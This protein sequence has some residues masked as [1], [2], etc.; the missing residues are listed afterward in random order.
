MGPPYIK[1]G[2]VFRKSA[3]QVRELLPPAL[4]FLADGLTDDTRVSALQSVLSAIPVTESQLVEIQKW[5]VQSTD[6][7]T[8]ALGITIVREYDA[9]EME[10]FPLLEFSGALNQYCEV[11]NWVE[12]Y[13]GRWECGTCRR[14]DWEQVRHLQVAPFPAVDFQRTN[15]GGW[16]IS[17]VVQRILDEIGL[18]GQGVI[19]RPLLDERRYKQLIVENV[20][21]VALVPPLVAKEICPECSL[22][23]SLTRSPARELIGNGEQGMV[24]NERIPLTVQTER[25]I[26]G[27]ALDSLPLLARSDQELGD[28][29]P[30][31]PHHKGDMFPEEEIGLSIPGESYQFDFISQSLYQRFMQEGITGLKYQPVFIER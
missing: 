1:V 19:L 2:V 6:T 28:F 4:S 9:V 8:L 24:I 14:V 31:D 15:L 18:L 10:Q 3:Q 26:C 27:D 20:L 7:G 30:G 21:P 22:P 11:E 5:G 17:P 25:K 12:A 29:R 13:Q 16:I 23:M